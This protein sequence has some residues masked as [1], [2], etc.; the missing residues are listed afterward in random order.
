MK[1]S[2]PRIVSF[3]LF[4]TLSTAALA[5]CTYT[6]Q[7]MDSFGDG[8]NGG[9]VTISNGGN[10][11]IYTLNN[12]TDDGTDS[13][14]SFQVIDGAPLV[15]STL[16]GSFPGEVSYNIYDNAGTLIFSVSSPANG[17]LFNGIA[18]CVACAP[19]LNFAVDNIWDNRARLRWQANIA[20]T[21]AP[22]N[23]RVIY[24]LQGFLPDAGDGDTLVVGLPR[25]TILGLQKK[26]WY[27]AY[28]EQFCD[29]A[30]GYS[31]RIGPLSFET[32]WTN[33]VGISGVVAPLSDCGLG[34]DSLKVILRNYGA[35][36]QSLITFRYAVNGTLAPVVP[37]ADGFYTGV[38]GKDSSVVIAFETLSDFS[39]SGEY[40]I[41][42]FTQLMTDEALD[43]DTFTYYLNSSLQP[44]YVQPFEVW[45]GG[46]TVSGQ[47][48]SWEFGTPNKLGIP[49]AASG[50]NAWVTSLTGLYNINELSYLESPC[51]D[52]SEETEDPAFRCSL[53][54]NMQEG[55][56]GGWLEM[57]TDEGQN[58][59]K[60][61]GQGEGVNW[62]NTNLSFLGFGD[63]WS[64]NSNGWITV[65][66][67]LPNSAG[68]SN[69]RLRF[70]M[71][72]T[73][74][75]QSTGGLGIDDVEIFQSFQ[76]DL[77]AITISTLGEQSECGLENDQITFT[78]A[79]FGSQPQT[80]IQVAY[81]VNGAAPVT[82][83]VLG[84]LPTDLM[85]SITFTVPIDSRDKSLE[86]K[87]W[88]IISGDQNLQNDT[89]TYLINHLP[90]TLPLQ[91]NFESYVAPPTDWAYTP[92]F[93]FSVTNGHN[94]LSN[95]LA[96]NLY[97]GNPSFTAA[98]PRA[99][100][101]QSGD[102]L[103]FQYRITSF[104]SNGMAPAI[105]QLGTKV[106]IR[107]S[108]NCGGSY[109][110]IYT[111][112]NFNHSPTSMLRTIK[113]PLENFVGDDIIIQFVGTWGS[114]DLWI[115]LDNIN[116]LSCASSMDLSAQ[117]TPATPGFSDG[118]ATVQVGL[119]NPPY[120][121]NWSNGGT[122]QTQQN[123]ESGMYGVTVLDAF[124]CS[125]E[126]SF[127]LG[128][129]STETL[130]SLAQMRLYP[131]PTSGLSTLEVNLSSPQDVQIEIIT[132]L[133]Q[134]IWSVSASAS[135]QLTR[136]IDLSQFPDGWYLVRLS[137][138]GETVTRKLIKR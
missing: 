33:D 63:A 128:T 34:M 49:A 42:V 127:N 82:Q 115:D 56:D 138:A 124:G 87:C 81:S 112:T 136:Q 109:Q 16:Q 78:F 13:T 135:A 102:S 119:G 43:N 77:S 125:D 41:E 47:N 132:P 54:R 11:N 20:G 108:S 28:V 22:L 94:N 61:G 3:A 74:F 18:E 120:T 83:L 4:L 86:I 80:G 96:F 85:Q 32:Y 100:T 1:F 129:S 66:H 123:L 114:G 10:I 113:L 92:F 25:V 35:A 107:V 97:G 122:G 39:N 46:W 50:Q 90:R 137:A 51:F 38:L 14:V 121:F 44:D 59:T 116:I 69:V 2:L 8:W 118:A 73:P 21:A 75:F 104:A 7:M 40:K 48:P 79:N 134:R 62:Y 89:F 91:E 126:L 103:N 5:Q 72:T 98:M 15:V 30:A 53:Y 19:P 31:N 88:T 67:S 70:V 12:F 111:V 45:D 93:G 60:V 17:V 9:S 55:F 130:E 37:P 99:G 133:G 65:R 106:E 57:S 101:V 29:T 26:T 105:L 58:W 95:V 64:G 24:G 84:T 52:F 23:W 110:T 36:P 76:K 27:D 117:V 68:E 71:A 6:L 131:N